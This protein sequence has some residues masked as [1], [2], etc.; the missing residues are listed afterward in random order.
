MENGETTIYK[1]K[2]NKPLK[3]GDR[4]KDNDGHIF[5]VIY[6]PEL[7]RVMADEPIAGQLFEIDDFELELLPLSDRRTDMAQQQLLGFFLRKKM[8]LTEFVNAMGLTKSEW[9]IIKDEY[10][11]S[12]M[13]EDD[14][15][16]IDLYISKAK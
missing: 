1:D 13:S 14:K 7:E 2:N 10:D 4:A 12:F 8:S 3:I 9:E 6:C 5:E 15:H 11:L 16:S